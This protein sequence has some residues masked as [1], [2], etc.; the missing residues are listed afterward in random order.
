MTK[1]RSMAERP[2]LAAIASLRF[3]VLGSWF[4][5]GL[6]GLGIGQCG[7]GEDWPEF[8]GPTGQGIVRD[9]SLPVEW[10]A[11]KH[12]AWK[13]PIPGRGWSSPV[14]SDGRVY[15]TT[16]VAKNSGS[17]D[18]SLQALCLD[19]SSGKV[20][21]QR[22]VFQ[23]DSASAPPIHSKNSHA[24]PTPLVR[25]GRLYVHFGHQGTAC[26]D[27][28]GRI[29]WRSTDL[30]YAPVH[31]NGGS[32][33]LVDDALIFSCD[34]NEKPFVAALDRNSGKVL[35]KTDRSG[36]A[37][38][39]FS[40][41]TPLL[42]K[43]A[44]RKQVVSAGSEMVAAYD[45]TT[46][47]EIWCVRHAGYSVVPRPV[48]GHGLVFI[49]TGYNSPALFAI[50]PGGDGDVTQTHVAWKTRRAASLTPSPLLVDDELYIVADNGIAACFD[51]ET[52]KIH[53]Q[54]RIGGAYSSSPIYAGR[55]IYF[56]NEDGV[57]TVIEAGRSYKELARNSLDERTLASFAAANGALFIRTEKNLSRIQNP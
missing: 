31:G 7:S 10:S 33:I 52:G 11:T 55:K 19:A 28:S 49:C 34:G 37:D 45:P 54:Y 8:R 35:W 24:S 17:R 36:D 50:R 6:L 18:Q 43:V 22:E 1:E 20:L 29:I 38:R 46:G 39:S 21:W 40:F 16:S 23:E 13:Q 15:L 47:R 30:K 9:G 44:G 14:V 42:I 57:C 51:A 53:W 27:L 4:F 5:F 12:V 32:P 25:D 2:K 3:L 41:S 48:Y 56:Q 26:L